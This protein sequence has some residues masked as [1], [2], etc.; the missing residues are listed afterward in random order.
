ML[1]PPT[2]QEVCPAIVFIR[3]VN[4]GVVEAFEA[5]SPSFNICDLLLGERWRCQ[6][7]ME[8]ENEIHVVSVQ[9]NPC[10]RN[11]R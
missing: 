7:R 4:N 9:K 11:S 1:R 10:G 3:D 6:V 8:Y 2:A 5:H